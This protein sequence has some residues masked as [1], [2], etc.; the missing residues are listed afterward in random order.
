MSPREKKL[1]MFMG[2]T[3]FVILNLILLNTVFLPRLQAAKAAVQAAET[4]LTTATSKIDQF[5][6]FEPR[7]DWVERSGTAA[8]DRFQVQSE[9]QQFLRR[10]ATARRLEIRDEDIL[11]YVEG[12]YFGRVKVS[13][14]V[15]GMEREVIS[16][17]TSIHR[18]EQRQVITMLEMKP[19]NND[20]TRIEVE[21]EVAKWIIPAE[22]I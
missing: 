22:E 9:L 7:M 10:Q 21:V 14:K 2:G 16:W 12:E 18:I 20:L 11:D 5:E 13:C 1:L 8:S 17:L 19:Q 3:L 4:S 15:T 6:Y